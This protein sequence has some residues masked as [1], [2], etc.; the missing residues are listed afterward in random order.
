MFRTLSLCVVAALLV[1]VLAHAEAP[2]AGKQLSDFPAGTWIGG[3]KGKGKKYMVVTPPEQFRSSPPFEVSNVLYLNRCKGGCMVTGGGINDARQHISTYIA[4]GPHTVSEFKNNAGQ[5]GAAADAEWNMLVQ[6]MKEIYS[7]FDIVVTDVA[8]LP[9]AGNWTE[10]IIAGQSEDVGLSQQIAG[11]APAHTSCEPNDNALSY[12]FSNNGYYLNFPT[13]QDRVNELCATAG[14]ESAHHYGLD[15]AYEYFDGQSACNDPMTYRTDCGGQRFFRNKAA[16]CG[17][18][19]VR[20]C[21]CG[22]LQNSH[23]K[24]LGVFGE[25]PNKTL[26]P[27]PTVMVNAPAA[28]TM[29]QEMQV[30]AFQAFSKRGIEKGELILNGY[31]WA[32]VKGNG[33]TGNGQTN[34]NYSIRLPAGVPNG[35]IDVQV[36]AYDDLGVM[37]ESQTVRVQK[38]A[39]CANADTCAKGQKCDGEG[40]CLW[41][42]PTGKLG[43]TCDYQQFC[44]SN[45]CVQ[46][47]AGGYCSQDCIIGVMDSCPMEFEC[48]A[49]GAGGACL[50]KE[51][52]G[53]CLGCSAGGRDA[54]WLHAGLSM[55][56]LALVVRRRRRTRDRL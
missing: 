38:G 16:K 1:P 29:V 12:T 48:V 47:E 27:A 18:D 56:V 41:D 54:M 46:T 42:P 36:R 35:V 30:V 11:V 44:E 28:G 20:M 53:G 19:M 10:A 17:E 8:P 21:F 15:H 32:E 14:Q 52:G 37:T 24:I 13:V 40:R 39:K 25:G 23:S 9:S 31:K 4:A 34:I 3:G 45:I 49:A 7:P 51:S 55:F 33:F 22:G 26:I 5:T 6:C 2:A 43:D 50:P